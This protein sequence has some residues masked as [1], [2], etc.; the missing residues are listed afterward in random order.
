ML[1]SKKSAVAGLL[2]SLALIGAGAVQ[3]VGAESPGNCTE[4]DKGQI[5]CIEVSEHR[6]VEQ[7]GT[8]RVDSKATQSCS[9]KGELTC[10]NTLVLEDEKS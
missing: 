9:G 1:Q 7:D 2:G 8:V 4:N 6:V 5:R 10:S 3:A